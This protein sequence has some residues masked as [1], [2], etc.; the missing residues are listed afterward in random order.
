ISGRRAPA[1]SPAGSLYQAGAMIIGGSDWDV[2]TYNLFRAFQ[3]GVTRTGGPGQKPLNLGES[4]PLAGDPARRPSRLRR[5]GERGRVVEPA[6]GPHARLAEAELS[7]GVPSSQSARKVR[8]E[9]G[10]AAAP[11]YRVAS[12]HADERNFNDRP[13]PLSGVE[14]VCLAAAVAA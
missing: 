14:G 1:I 10:E 9:L 6:R 8:Q 3:V 7:L 12:I 2:S 13:G 5:R 11:W 4:I